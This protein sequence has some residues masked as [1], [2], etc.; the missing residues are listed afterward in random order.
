M[1]NIYEKLNFTIPNNALTIHNVLN[2][3]GYETYFV[4]GAL[5]DLFMNYYFNSDYKIKDWDITTTA[6]YLD[7]FNIFNKILRVNENGRIV[8][9]IS[10]SEILIP[11]IETT[12]VFINNHMFEVTPM[13]FFDEEQL[14]FTSNIID[15]LS[16]R[17]FT[18]N[19][20]AYSPKFGWITDFENA[21]G[22]H[23]DALNDIKNKIIRCTENADKS[24]KRNRF[25][26]LRAIMFANRFDFEIEESTLNSIKE[27]ISSVNLINKGKMFIA[28]EKIILTKCSDKIWYIKSTGLLNYLCD[29]WNNDLS[30]EFI[31]LLII[32]NTVC[33][34][35]FMERIKYIYD[36]FSN[37]DVLKKIYKGFGVN[38]EYIFKLDL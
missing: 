17:D 2:N 20:I 25:N 36:N 31:K 13:H 22:S 3:K 21:E 27:N 28:F 5:R 18:M 14:L 16:K 37:K 24:F 30:D 4:G 32:T 34:D 1:N 26:I 15:D 12:G 10:K 38:K 11:A 6:R 9:K 35:S 19:A 23:I 33:S 7:M 29:E 8:S